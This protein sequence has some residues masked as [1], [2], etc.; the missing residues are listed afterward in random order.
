[1]DEELADRLRR[2]ESLVQSLGAQVQPEDESSPP[3]ESPDKESSPAIKEEETHEM[4]F[5]R[6]KKEWHELIK[7]HREREEKDQP[8]VNN[9]STRFGKLIVHEGR[10]RYITPG[11]WS[12]LKSELDDIKSDRELL[13]DLDEDEDDYPSPGTSISN[14]TNQPAFIF[15]ML[16][17]NVDMAQLHPPPE[18]VPMYWQ[19]FKE[20]VDALV[21]T[22][23]IPSREGMIMN[24]TKQL[25]SLDR[26]Q[27]CTMF[28]IYFAAITS[29]KQE[30]CKYRFGESKADLLARYRFGMEQ[31]LARADFL[32]TDSVFVLQAFV[33]FLACLR[34]NENPRVVW[35]LTSLAVRIAQGLGLHR[36]GDHYT[37]LTPYKREMRRRVWWHTAVL[38]MRAS[39][40][41]GSDPSIYDLMS[42]AQLP[43]NLNDSDITFE[44]TEI[45]ES[46]VGCTDMTFSLIR[47]EINRALRHMHLLPAGVKCPKRGKHHFN[48]PFEK[49]IEKLN[50]LEKYI[51]EQ[52]LKDADLSIPLHWLTVTSAR[53]IIAKLR[54]V[55]MVLEYLWVRTDLD[56]DALCSFPTRGW[57]SQS[58]SRCSRPAI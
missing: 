46:R 58:A 13:D 20:N 21:K 18:H 35:S 43:R 16:S 26:A 49:R 57:W 55:S 12:S 15:N 11:L 50:N 10:S 39:E 19:L 31:S 38:D 37:N 27:E 2:L 7:E 54:L 4:K 40:D 14:S 42:D 24:N 23:H 29:I 48:M 45:P 5:V 52:Y 28:S 36:D 22:Y 8:D 51:E 34:P 47:F 1:M 41:L 33:V 30:E 56:A 9:L 3:P 44:M 17:T 6:V 32:K 25:D 53:L